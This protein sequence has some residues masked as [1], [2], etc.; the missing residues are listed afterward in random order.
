MSIE[1]MEGTT[2]GPFVY[3]T[4]PEKV[5]EYTTLVG[6]TEAVP[7]SLAGALLFVVTPHLLSDPRAGES[8]RS[9]IHGDQ[10]FTWHAPIPSGAAL[11]VSGTVRRVRGR[12]EVFFTS[13]DLEVALDGAP[14]VTGAS[15]F[16]M[17]AGST[18]G[19]SEERPEPDPNEGHVDVVDG[20]VSDAASLVG[21]FGASRSDLVRYA[22]ASRD[23][24]P[25]HWDHAAA[26]AA[27]LPGIVV[28][29][30]FQSGWVTEAA[31]RLGLEPSS[32]KFRYR[33]PLPAGTKAE[34][35]A[36]AKEGSTVM[37]LADSDGPYLTATF[38]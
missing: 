31:V 13:F 30:L 20:T 34:L 28:H 9:V 22:G 33:R 3:R 16:L 7:R 18:T 38:E 36:V 23:W 5:A 8:T 35:S 6:G 4:D 29:G 27:G 24:N 10:A 12:G 15:T 37:E 26:V 1:E 2:Y 21:R 19:G 11:D 32:A 25:I 14:L 17:S